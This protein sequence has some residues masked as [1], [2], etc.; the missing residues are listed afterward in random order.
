MIISAIPA[1]DFDAVKEE[2]AKELHLSTMPAS[3][4]ALLEDGQGNLVF[5]EFKNC[6]ITKN[7]QYEIRKKIYDSCLI[8]SDLT[9]ETLS[10]M[11]KNMDYILVYNESENLRNTDDKS[12]E[13]K[14]KTVQQSPSQD[15]LAKT[16][17]GYSGKE[18]IHFGLNKFKTYCFRDVHSYTETEFINYLSHIK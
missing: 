9:S 6:K 17:I 12:I 15:L 1:V 7:L 11:R 3:N 18:F 2:Y 14:N 13:A 4:D 5:V 16:I 8:F 10:Y